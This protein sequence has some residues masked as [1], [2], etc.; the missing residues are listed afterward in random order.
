MAADIHLNSVRIGSIISDLP[1]PLNEKRPSSVEGLDDLLGQTWDIG[2]GGFARLVRIN[3]A[4]TSPGK[5]LY[6]YSNT[7]AFD[8]VQSTT[9]GNTI[10]PCGV[11]HEDLENLGPRVEVEVIAPGE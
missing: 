6:I 2:N 7:D 8:V 5:M 4:Q 11:S 1:F 3:G 9:A 10:I